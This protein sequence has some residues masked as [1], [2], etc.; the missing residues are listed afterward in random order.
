MSYAERRR[1][2]ENEYEVFMTAYDDWVRQVTGLDRRKPS[3]ESHQ[4]TLTFMGSDTVMVGEKWT[5][6]VGT[7]EEAAMRRLYNVVMANRQTEEVKE[8][9][10][11]ARNM[12][13]AKTKMLI[14]HEVSEHAIEQWVVKCFEIGEVPVME[15][16]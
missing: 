14:R 13:E 2:L 4:R 15:D 6:T 16:K 8:D 1:A 3:R 10:I 9:Y 7:P 11:F 12:D 5:L